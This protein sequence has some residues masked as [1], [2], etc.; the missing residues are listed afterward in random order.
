MVFTPDGK[1]GDQREP[2]FAAIAAVRATGR[3]HVI[4][5]IGFGKLRTSTLLETDNVIFLQG[6][7]QLNEVGDRRKLKSI[8]A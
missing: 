1:G 4:R 6:K 2:S 7:L 5:G 8:H 3:Y